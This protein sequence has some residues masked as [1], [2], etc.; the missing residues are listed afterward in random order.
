MDLVYKGTT[1]HLPAERIPKCQY[2]N[3]MLEEKI[4]QIDLPELLNITVDDLVDFIACLEWS[5]GDSSK[6]KVKNP[7]RLAFL[8]QY[9]LCKHAEVVAFLCGQ[10]MFSKE[11]WLAKLALP[12]WRFAH[13]KIVRLL[14]SLGDLRDLE[15]S[16]E[17]TK[18][19]HLKLIQ[20]IKASPEAWQ[21]ALVIN[22]ISK[23]DR[24]E[25]AQYLEARKTHW[26]GTKISQ[27]EVKNL[28]SDVHKAYTLF[29]P[30]WKR[31]IAEWV[32][33]LANSTCRNALAETATIEEAIHSVYPLVFVGGEG[34]ERV[35]VVAHPRAQ[36]T[37]FLSHNGFC[38]CWTP[39]DIGGPDVFGG[40]LSHQEIY[41]EFRRRRK[42]A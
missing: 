13:G 21:E 17:Q 9:F 38:W 37:D 33:P 14:C 1:L 11:E 32:L 20:K 22:L 24:F 18:L 6:P 35:W 16:K 10:Q 26:D 23:F 4:T 28:V 25:G 8:S 41:E 5:P 31:D 19:D 27:E 30:V 3:S 36:E 40:R 42:L 12:E 34:A 2:F 39:L 29:K 7:D 15:A